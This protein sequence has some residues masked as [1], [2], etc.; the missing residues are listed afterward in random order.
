MTRINFIKKLPKILGRFIGVDLSR[1]IMSRA[2]H[3]ISKS[4]PFLPTLTYIYPTDFAPEKLAHTLF[5][6]YG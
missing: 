5:T 4:N 3:F 1:H 6:G 2:G